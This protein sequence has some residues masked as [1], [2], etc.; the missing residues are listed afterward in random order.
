MRTVGIEAVRS[1][2]K[3]SEYDRDWPS[4]AGPA[5]TR[6][7]A[8]FTAARRPPTRQRRQRPGNTGLEYPPPGL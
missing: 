2:A 6:T 3:I 8:R 4:R 7:W 1:P 5:G